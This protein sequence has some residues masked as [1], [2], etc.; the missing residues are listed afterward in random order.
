MMASGAVFGGVSFA[1]YPLCVAHTNDH[2]TPD[3]RV[4]ASS[5]LVLAYSLGAVAGPMAGVGFMSAF[6]PRG[7]FVFIGFCAMAVL[8]F[9]LWRLRAAPP[10]PATQQM[11]YQIL[12]RT[13]PAMAALDPL[14][15]DT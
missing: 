15:R 4:G 9:A 6:G 11:P 8:G 10:V 2:L 7:L 13:T 1:L 5:G 14:A 12:P 3:Q